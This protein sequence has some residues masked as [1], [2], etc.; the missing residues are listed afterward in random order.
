M[1]IARTKTKAIAILAVLSVAIALC[2]LLRTPEYRAEFRSDAD[3]AIP[4]VVNS[5]SEYDSPG[6]SA[7]T[8]VP[9]AREVELLFVD[10][11]SEDPIPGVVVSD[12][13]S[14]LIGTSRMD[15]RI[16]VPRG[17]NEILCRH[18]DYRE[19]R[20]KTRG[21]KSDSITIVLQRLPVSTGRVVDIAGYPVPS[22]T[23]VFERVAR[24]VSNPDGSASDSSEST[25]PEAPT[26]PL[27]NTTT[28]DADGRF[29]LRHP[30]TGAYFVAIKAG[31]LRVVQLKHNGSHVKK[32]ASIPV[33]INMN[34]TWEI[35]VGCPWYVA[36]DFTSACPHH[37]NHQLN[38][39]NGV[40]FTYNHGSGTKTGELSVEDHL[41]RHIA[42]AVIGA[43]AREVL[44]RRLV[45]VVA[46]STTSGPSSTRS[47]VIANWPGGGIKHVQGEFLPFHEDSRIVWTRARLFEDCVGHALVSV[48]GPESYVLE[49]SKTGGI[50]VS[51]SKRNNNQHEFDVIAGSYFVMTPRKPND[52]TPAEQL[53]RSATF[54]VSK[55]ET[56]SIDVSSY[57]YSDVGCEVIWKGKSLAGSPAPNFAIGLSGNGL[58]LVARKAVDSKL[59]M[60]LKPG[61]YRYSVQIDGQAEIR[62]FEMAIGFDEKTKVID[63]DCF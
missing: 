9:F 48:T 14:S 40:S 60:R 11:I 46:F 22:A 32:I 23:L 42:E 7:V 41:K 62:R 35:K 55:G 17:E 50:Q 43:D 57:R 38:S 47:D 28:T 3:S 37:G 61:R 53:R 63:V 21:R 26:P 20:V 34:N 24:P 54:A 30:D 18:A 15:G 13:D 59:Q 27:V 36:V 5:R 19:V 4:P 29:E 16:S 2:L 56:K 8:S 25:R 45:I 44:D 31:N 1:Q 52:M 49:A 10:A 33:A 51:P 39:G 12:R 58:R 6:H